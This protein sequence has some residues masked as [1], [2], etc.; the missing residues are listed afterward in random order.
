MNDLSKQLVFT[1]DTCITCNKCISVC[2]ALTVNHAV[3]D[4]STGKDA[5]HI[6]GKYCIACG[7]CFD[8]CKHEGRIYEDDTERF[9]E[10]LKR[11][12][13]ISLLIA[14][15]FLANYPDDYEKILGQLRRLGVNRLIS[16][17]FGA[18]ITTWAYINY[19]STHP[20]TG[21]IS[22][23]CPAIVDYIEKYTPSLLPKLMPIHSPMMCAAIYTKK[24][25]KV[26][27][28]LAF[29]S[30]CIAKKHEIDDPNT[31][32]YISYNVTF[33]HLL[34]YLKAHPVKVYDKV[35]DEIEY[36]LGSIYPMP[37]GLK[38]NV[39]WF[40]GEDTFVRQVEGE[41]NA[42]RFLE[43]YAKRVASGKPLPFLVDILNCEKGCIYGT[44]TTPNKSDDVLYALEKIKLNSKKAHASSPW[45]SHLT[46]SKRLARLNKQFKHLQIED[47]I[48]E[49]TDRSDQIIVKEPTTKELDTIFQSMNKLSDSE[50]HID[51][52]ACGYNSCKDMA[53]AIFNH[54]NKPENC[55]Y[56]AHKQLQ[57]EKEEIENFSYELEAKNS[58]INHR[59]E[60]ISD[61]VEKVTANFKQ[62]DHSISELTV[63]NNQNATDAQT[64]S[65]A[66]NEVADFCS[67][68]EASFAQ[69]NEVLEKLENNNA[70]I[71]SIASQ[72]NL[73]SLN[74]SIEAARAGDSGKGFAIVAD[75]IKSL[76]GFSKDSAEASNQNKEEILVVLTALIEQSTH[77]M[78]TISALNQ[79][80]DELASSAEEIA[81]STEILSSVSSTLKEKME[82]LTKM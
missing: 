23:P 36:G 69:I 57:L 33:D 10:D 44:G 11:G 20:L 3:T 5:I 47:F 63:V 6:H 68:I 26:T 56:F 80:T 49:Y 8:A 48:R 12:K 70:T 54:C 34:A 55:I 41:Q 29:L 79:R 67:R 30:P 60:V 17:S 45:N 64:I 78:E 62:L 40:C 27:D 28:D 7:A 46:P 37:G 72:T 52:S 51:C 73:L 59:N 42:Y 1:T 9:I 2:P 75:Q 66:V 39:H 14:P 76:S 50:R 31:H 61:V 15:A 13:K 25:E 18:D 71:T 82:Q 35:S 32:G 53:V 74:A 77:L 16:V 38:E 24:Y 21:A 81:A 58:E 4:A 22:Q 43:D 65:A 19:L